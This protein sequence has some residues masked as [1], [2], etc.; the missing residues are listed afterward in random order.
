MNMFL[1]KMMNWRLK[2]DAGQLN[3]HSAD[4]Y[5]RFV[6]SGSF[7]LIIVSNVVGTNTN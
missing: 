2:H 1:L 3:F 7:T 5:K 4:A 6:L